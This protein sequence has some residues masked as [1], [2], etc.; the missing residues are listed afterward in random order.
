MAADTTARAEHRQQRRERRV[1]RADRREELLDAAIDGLRKHGPNA[2]MDQL[3]AAAGITKPILYRHFG[4]RFGLANAIAERFGGELERAL[5]A[6]ASK[7]NS[8]TRSVLVEVVDAFVGH[9][10]RDPAVYRF[11]VQGA[12]RD[13]VQVSEFLGNISNYIAAAIGEQQRS[14]GRDSG[15]AEVIARGVVSFVHAAG[16]WWVDHQTMPRARLV[17]YMAD[18]LNEGFN[19]Q[20]GSTE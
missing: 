16:D 7:E 6:A 1:H 10:E 11:L 15:G 5:V 14:A 3:A 12:N 8:N 13:V 4:D 17:A 2:S 19:G 9:I 20:W 18:F